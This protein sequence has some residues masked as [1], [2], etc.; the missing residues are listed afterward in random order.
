MASK[1][2]CEADSDTETE[3]LQEDHDEDISAEVPP[4]EPTQCLFCSTASTT[5]DA[6]LAHMHK[7][8]GL[9][10]PT[11]LADNTLHLSVE[12]KTLLQYLHLVIHGYH[13]CLACHT[14]RHSA[15]A[16]V[17]H[18]LG[19]GHCRVD[20]DIDGESEFLDFY[21]AEGVS[22]GE[23]SEGS[24][25]G[26]SAIVASSSKH[27]GGKTNSRVD[28]NTMRLSS[29][30]LLS[31]RST[32]P[33]PRANRKPLAESKKHNRHDVDFFLEDL[34]PLNTT[35]ANNIP[36]ENEATPSDP[37]TQQETSLS[38][39]DRRLLAGGTGHKTALT[40]ALSKMSANDRA[41]L[42]H[43]TPAERRATVVKQ[44]K[45]QEKRAHAERKYW[46]KVELCPNKPQSGLKR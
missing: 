19:K 34:M 46:S 24:S 21:E 37:S 5:L 41:A 29:G 25:S 35:D 36:T 31:H 2:N 9:M 10:L 27:I 15:A 44:F 4:F 12:L 23:D 3:N 20:L 38:R 28:K 32:P 14:Q 11:S 16:V 18:M 40:I 42:A 7:K 26:G 17:Q 22:E 8:H 13:E 30:K 45:Q 1:E 33:T 43:L 6:N 39:A